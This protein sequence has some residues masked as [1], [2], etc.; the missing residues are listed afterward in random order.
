MIK[1]DRLREL[2]QQKGLTQG[3]LGNIISVTK[4]S[5]CC[6]EKETRTPTVENL[7]DLML[8]FGVSADYLIGSDI[9][10]T[11]K[12]DKKNNYYLSNEEIKFLAELRKNKY[13]YTILIDDPVRG[14]ELL[15]KKIG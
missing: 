1:G 14:I 13:I 10:V 2:R 12:D 11:V 15:N 3:E 6:Y 8:Y 4:A 7:M 5:I 9:L